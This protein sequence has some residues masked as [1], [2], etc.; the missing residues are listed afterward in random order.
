MRSTGRWSP[1]GSSTSLAAPTRVS[2]DVENE[3]V[4]AGYEVRR[5]SGPTRFETAEAI[6][7]ETIFDLGQSGLPPRDVVVAYGLNWPDAITGGA[8]VNARAGALLVL[9]DTTS[10]H[11]AAARIISQSNPDRTILVGGYRCDRDGGR[12]LSAEPA[13]CRGC[14]PDGHRGRGGRHPVARDPGQR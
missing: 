13:T 11:P 5:L 2:V 9:S 4:G 6:A 10:L 1:A 3:L 14:E 7:Q 8:W 12:E